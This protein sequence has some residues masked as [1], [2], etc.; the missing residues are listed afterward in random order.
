MT[1]FKIM[2][3]N[4]TQVQAKLKATSNSDRHEK[5]TVGTHTNTKWLTVCVL[6]KLQK[7]SLVRTMCWCFMSKCAK[8]QMKIKLSAMA[9]NKS[10]GSQSISLHVIYSRLKSNHNLNSPV[11]GT[12]QQSVNGTNYTTEQASSVVTV[13]KCFLLVGCKAVTGLATFSAHIVII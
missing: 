10:S 4:F 3:R 13:S 8:F 7:I 2:M 5:A 1:I 12:N 11:T 9:S 6:F